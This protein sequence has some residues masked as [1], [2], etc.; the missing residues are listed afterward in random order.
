MS[1]KYNYLSR[2][3]Y[4]IAFNSLVALVALAFRTPV[5]AEINI[6]TLRFCAVAS[7]TMFT[8]GVGCSVYYYLSKLYYLIAFIFLVALTVLTFRTPVTAEANIIILRYYAVASLAGG[9]IGCAVGMERRIDKK[10]NKTE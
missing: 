5:T 8:V 10:R 4:I 1:D 6:I 7:L 2:I 3:C 9:V